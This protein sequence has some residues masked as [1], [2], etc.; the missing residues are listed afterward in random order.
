M[1][2]N[3]KEIFDKKKTKSLPIDKQMRKNIKIENLKSKRRNELIDMYRVYINCGFEAVKQQFNY[4]YSRNNL[5]MA[6]KKY[7]DEFVP[8]RG[9]RR[10]N[11]S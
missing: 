4:K 9:K 3:N 5:L 6:F 1:D 10:Y 8:Q 2:F 11:K 7:I